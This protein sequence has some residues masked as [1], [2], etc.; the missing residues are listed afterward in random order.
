MLRNDISYLEGEED[1]EKLF[2]E[3]IRKDLNLIG[4]SEDLVSD[5]TVTLFDDTLI[6]VTDL[7]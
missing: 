6:H 7:T 4:L 2:L 3:T 1:H 5:R